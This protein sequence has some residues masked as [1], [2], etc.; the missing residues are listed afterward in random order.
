MQGN[1]SPSMPDL[2]V[3][4]PGVRKLLLELDAKSP[5]ANTAEGMPMRA[6][7]IP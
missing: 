7:G 4:V 5:R 3:G 6:L 2:T 1:P